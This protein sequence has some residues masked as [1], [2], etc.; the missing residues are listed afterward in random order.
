MTITI[1]TA[2]SRTIEAGTAAWKLRVDC[3]GELVATFNQE[4]RPTSAQVSAAIR[5]FIEAGA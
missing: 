3:T 4:R 1:S 2:L 5:R